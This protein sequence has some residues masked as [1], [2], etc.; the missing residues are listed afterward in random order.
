[1]NLENDTLVSET[2]SLS[3]MLL[4]FGAY[5]GLSVQQIAEIAP[6]YVK[7]LRTRWWIDEDIYQDAV[8]IELPL[9]KTSPQED[10]AA[11]HGA[12][13][14]QCVTEQSNSTNHSGGLQ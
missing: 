2:E 11:W 9:P 5:E 6:G 12:P 8:K 10:W 7:W 13:I 3:G 14:K 1:M 4:T